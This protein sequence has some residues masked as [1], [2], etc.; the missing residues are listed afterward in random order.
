LPS[1][2]ETTLAIAKHGKKY[3]AA[4]QKVEPRKLDAPE[5]GVKLIQETAYATVDESGELHIRTGLYPRPADQVG[6][7][8]A[9]RIASEYASRT[10]LIVP[11]VSSGHSVMGC[12]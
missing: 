5:E 12:P 7:G 2:T 9:A 3:A 4:A 1:R 10:P 11:I 6:R 8:S